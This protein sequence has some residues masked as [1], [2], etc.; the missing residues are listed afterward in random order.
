[1]KRQMEL[2]EAFEKRLLDS[3]ADGNSAR[4]ETTAF[5]DLGYFEA[6]PED[7]DEA[8]LWTSTTRDRLLLGARRDAAKLRLD[9][10]ANLRNHQQFMGETTRSLRAISIVVAIILGYVVLRPWLGW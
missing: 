3:G 8:L 1:M 2:Q 9:V 5:A 10:E 6:E 7:L 4:A